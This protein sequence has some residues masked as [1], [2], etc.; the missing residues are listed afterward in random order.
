M[1]LISV[2]IPTYNRA[3]MLGDALDSLRRQ[4]HTDWEAIVVDD[5]STD[6]IGEVM[7]R[8]TN[9]ARIRY[10]HQANK[11]L[12]GARNTGIRAAKGDY[13]ALL[14][15][16]DVCL[17][18]RLRNQLAV[19]QA[20]PTIGL[21]AGG[22]IETDRNLKPIRPVENWYG[23]PQLRLQDFLYT[24]PFCPSAV[25]ARRECFER[26]GYFDESMKRA[27]DWDM[28]LRMVVTGCECMW[29]R[30]PACLYRLHGSNMM[31]DAALMR[32]GMLTAF[33]KLYAH[34]DLPEDVRAQRNRVYANVHMNTAG[35]FYAAGD[36]EQGCAS[37]QKAIQLNPEMVDGEPPQVLGSLASFA[38]MP[39]SGDP[40]A[41]MDRV[42]SHLPENPV[43][44]AWSPRRAQGLWHAVAAFE[45]AQRRERQPVIQHAM[46]AIWQSPVWLRNR[47]LLAITGRAL[48]K[49]NA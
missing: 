41:F 35:R 2:I 8:Y 13:V 28:W 29:L 38:L 25:M 11:G 30:E 18:D 47:G 34:R 40:A 24:A 9:D 33:D 3:D 45:A 12:S 48:L 6:A 20:Q 44:A 27:E 5:G 46:K 7:A 43:L 19:F 36:G 42:M 17:P 16:D 32:D 15:S 37:L 49:M 23:T 31:R 22:C 21:V 1:I 10:I 4:S 14:D 26:A 39:M